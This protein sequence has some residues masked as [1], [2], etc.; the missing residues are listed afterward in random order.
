MI[1]QTR[2][3]TR[4]YKFTRLDPQGEVITAIPD[5]LYFTVKTSYNTPNFVI[6]KTLDDM[7]IDEENVYH[8]T[9]EPNDTEQLPYGTY[10][11]D[12][13]VTQDGVVTTIAKDKFVLTQEAT[14]VINEG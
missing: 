5:S 4:S 7:T 8:F 10:V 6:Q 3:D 9:I 11:F 2:G 13:Q 1:K 12:I 14:W